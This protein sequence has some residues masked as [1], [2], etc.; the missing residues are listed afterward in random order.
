MT[1]L[2]LVAVVLGFSLGC[3]STTKKSCTCPSDP[4]PPPVVKAT[5]EPS[6]AAPR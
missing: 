3:K 1:K 4:F 5:P 6:F 2:L